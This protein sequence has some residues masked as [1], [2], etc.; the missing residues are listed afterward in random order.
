ME[1]DMS[2]R[3]PWLAA[4]MSL[5][6]PG[7]GQL[8]NGQ[9]NRAIWFFLTFAGF[10]LPGAI[11]AVYLPTRLMLPVFLGCHVIGFITWIYSVV[12]AYIQAK[13]L[14]GYIPKP[15][16][17][18]GVYALILVMFC[19]V[20]LPL[21]INYVRQHQVQSF[22]IPTN[23]MNPT[24]QKGDF[25]FTDMRYN[26]PG[27]S[28]RVQ[29]GDVVIFVFPNDRT[30][31]YVKRIIGLPGDTVDINNGRVSVNSE[32]LLPKP[33]Q[34]PTVE[35]SAGKRWNITDTAIEGEN[36]TVEVGHGEVFVMG[37]NRGFSNDSRKFG[38]VPLVDVVGK[39]RQIWFSKNDE[40]SQW[41]RIGTVLQ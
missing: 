35:E 30:Q 26:C 37:D 16:Q 13:K 23:S 6:L 40:G 39:V 5:V 19:F 34:E 38:T 21:V 7:Y 17:S 25:I 29:R 33:F 27:C 12:D 28:N 3:I 15:W 24:L 31:Y 11:L 41:S 14:A 4:I 36:L 18:T 10:L 22:F 1:S 2:R 32:R 20:V 9:V 8:Y